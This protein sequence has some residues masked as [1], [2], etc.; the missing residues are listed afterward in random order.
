MPAV[1]AQASVG[2]EVATD[3]AAKLKTGGTTKHQ[4]QSV[5]PIFPPEL[6]ARVMPE[7]TIPGPLATWHR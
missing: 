7:L 5:E 6:K 4:H 2:G 1:A 3:S